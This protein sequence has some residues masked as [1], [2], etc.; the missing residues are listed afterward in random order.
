MNNENKKGN[1]TLPTCG[2]LKKHFTHL[3]FKKWHFAYLWSNML[4]KRLL[5]SVLPLL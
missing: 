2:L 5:T 4:I 3:W 1:Y